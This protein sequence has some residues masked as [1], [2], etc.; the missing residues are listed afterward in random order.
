[1]SPFA[2]P[3]HESIEQREMQQELENQR[4]AQ[5]AAAA[6]AAAAAA[7]PTPVVA[8]ASP[9]GES[10]GQGEIRVVKGTFV[11]NLEDELI[12]EVRSRSFA[13]AHRRDH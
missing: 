4:Q 12:F 13:L 5:V 9:F 6:A 1:M 8:V 11:P 2:D 10:E 7:P 3:H